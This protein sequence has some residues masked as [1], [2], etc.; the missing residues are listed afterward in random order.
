MDGNL[1]FILRWN[2]YQIHHHPT[3]LNRLEIID[4]SKLKVVVLFTKYLAR[5]GI[6]GN[7]IGMYA[8]HCKYKCYN[9]EWCLFDTKLCK[10]FISE[11][12]KRNTFYQYGLT[13]ILPLMRNYIHHKVWDEIN[14]LSSNINDVA[15]EVR[16][17]K[18]YFIP[19]LIGSVVT[20]PCG[21]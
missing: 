18:S 21:D 6:V 9:F 1:C 12:E 10:D 20:Y 5:E 19:I 13:L 11:I 7:Q 3:D 15:F 4:T 17:W 2:I 14:Y 16:E 8:L